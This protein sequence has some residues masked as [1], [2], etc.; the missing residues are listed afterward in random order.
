M[1][2]ITGDLVEV[3]YCIEVSGCTNP[4]VNRLP[5]CL[6]GEGG[7]IVIRSYKGRDGRADDLDVVTVSTRDHLLVSRNAPSHQRF[8]LSAG[9]IARTRQ[10]A[11]V[12]DSF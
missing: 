9:G 6:V 10:Q 2:R 8:V 1:F 4:I 11:D 7:M 5:V 3:G 12:V